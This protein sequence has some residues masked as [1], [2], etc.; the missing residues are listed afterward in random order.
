MGRET[1]HVKHIAN[2]VLNGIHAVEPNSPAIQ[3]VVLRDLIDLLTVEACAR[4]LQVAHR[5]RIQRTGT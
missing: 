4:E 2:R 5:Q 3:A 1:K